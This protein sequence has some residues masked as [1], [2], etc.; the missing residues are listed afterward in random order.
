MKNKK[1]YHK[2]IL[3]RIKREIKK[4]PPLS[5]HEIAKRVGISTTG[6]F[7]FVR[8]YDLKKKSN[9]NLGKRKKYNKKKRF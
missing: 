9:R 8:Q 4:E 5:W 7:N 3:D 1:I 6:I 2:A